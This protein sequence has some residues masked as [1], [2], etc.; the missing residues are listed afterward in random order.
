[1]YARALQMFR[2]SHRRVSCALLGILCTSTG[3]AR[4]PAHPHVFKEPHA[5]LRDPHMSKGAAES[6]CL[7]TQQDHVIILTNDGLAVDMHQ[8][9]S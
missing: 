9:P 8:K 6:C 1:M 3:S 2:E 7:S 4:H 5:A